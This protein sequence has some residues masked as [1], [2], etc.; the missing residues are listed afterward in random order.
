MKAPSVAVAEPDVQAREAAPAA[1]PRTRPFYWSLRREL[2]ENRSVY[3]APLGVGAFAVVALVIHAV[4]MPSHM[5]GMLANDPASAGSASVTYRVAAMLMLATAFVVAAFYCLEALSS[6]R[7]DRSILFWK[8]L[9]VSDL[10]AVLSKASIPLV[11]LPLITMAAI[12]AMHLTILLLSVAA[13]LVQGQ[14]AAPLWREVQLFKLWL[15]MAYSL[16]AITLWHAPIHGFLLLVSGWARRTAALWA[17]LPLLAIGLLEKL[18]MD[19]TYV[20]TQVSHRLVGWHGQAFAVQP[21]DSLLF[22]P[23][24]P[25]TPDRFLGTPSLWIG[26]ALA[27]VFIAGAVRMRRVREPV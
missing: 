23:Q 20:A 8:S 6:E 5:P 3:L 7:R 13:L 17:V 18:T 24:T 21:R 9:P 10:A 14:S 19:T 15:A 11:V 12:V 1:L 22:D 25:L 16:A 4:T 2:W 27:A 26:L